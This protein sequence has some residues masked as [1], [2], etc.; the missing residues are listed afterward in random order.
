MEQ[1]FL[2][3]FD[4]KFFDY[5]RIDAGE[6]FDKIKDQDLEDAYFADEEPN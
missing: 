5:S 3:G 2:D 1:R 6:E 4:L